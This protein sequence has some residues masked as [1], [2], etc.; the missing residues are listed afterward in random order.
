V[1]APDKW[2]WHPDIWYLVRGAYHLLTH[3]VPVVMAAHKNVI[4]NGFVIVYSWLGVFGPLADV[5]DDHA[6]HFCN[7]YVFAKDV[8][9]DLRRKKEIIG[10]LLTKS[11]RLKLC[12][13]EWRLYLGG[14]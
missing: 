10:Y 7:F 8:R 12:L 14:G 5:V 2:M 6:L 9:S 13:I 3:L 11:L 4:W 1:D